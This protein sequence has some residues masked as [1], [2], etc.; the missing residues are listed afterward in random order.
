MDGDRIMKLHALAGLPRSG[1]TLLGNVLAQHPDVHVSGTSA[2]PLC[3]EQIVNVL[4]TAPEVQSDLANVPG[5]YE[6][7]VAAMRS[8][9]EG[10]YGGQGTVFD[11]GRGWVM[12]RALL[13]QLFPGSQLVVCVRDPRDVVA[14][15][16]RQNRETAAFN[17]P[18]GREITRSTELAMRP[19]G[20]VGGPCRFV[21]DLIRRNY[22]GVQ[23]VRYES[24]VR[25]P[26]ITVERIVSACGLAPF[27]FDYDGVE[28]Q[29]SDLDALYLNKFPHDGSGAIKPTGR[30]WHDVLDP[31]IAARIAASYPLYMQTFSYEGSSR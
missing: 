6:R 16:E 15:I 31:Q 1:T 14:S 28:N 4:S 18:L 29:A 24:F 22:D 10:W 25:D 12:H 27:E 3:V 21:E 11:K 7:Y 20:M 19:D 17:S 8:F 5:A 9:C 13:E 30:S 23:F 2:L 26:Y